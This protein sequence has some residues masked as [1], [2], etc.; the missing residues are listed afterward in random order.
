M[1]PGRLLGV[2]RLQHLPEGA[3]RGRHRAAEADHLRRGVPS[4]LRYML[5]ISSAALHLFS[6]PR[7]AISADRPAAADILN[8]LILSFLFRF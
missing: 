5:S 2:G 4:L 3:G 1:V 8:S 7:A 6:A